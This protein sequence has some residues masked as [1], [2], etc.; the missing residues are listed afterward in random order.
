[1]IL[2]L[3]VGTKVL[4]MPT[5][6]NKVKKLTGEALTNMTTPSKTQSPTAPH[7]YPH[8]TV[9]SDAAATIRKEANKW[10]EDT[11]AKLFEQGMQIIYGGTGPGSAKVRS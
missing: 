5:K 2:L 8:K 11:R 6:R 10:S 3:S 9:G 4:H 1:M 7:P